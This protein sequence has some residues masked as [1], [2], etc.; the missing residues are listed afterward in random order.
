MTQI[1]TLRGIGEN[2]L[3]Q[4]QQKAGKQ[5]EMAA[6]QCRN[7]NEMLNLYLACNCH[8]SATAVNVVYKGLNV[9][10]PFPNIFD[11]FVDLDGNIIRKPRQANIGLYFIYCVQIYNL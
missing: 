3:K 4:P 9:S 8:A 11:Q 7:I 6:Y 10:A 5:K 2:R 1:I